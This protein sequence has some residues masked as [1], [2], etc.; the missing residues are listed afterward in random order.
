MMISMSPNH[1]AGLKKIR[2]IC[3]LPHVFLVYKIT[4]TYR[5]FFCI[6]FVGLH[7]LSNKTRKNLLKV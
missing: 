4:Q 7:H 6:I 3:Y 5:A 1:S 2:K